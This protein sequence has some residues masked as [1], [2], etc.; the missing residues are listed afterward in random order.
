MKRASG[1]S[2]LYTGA[3]ALLASSATVVDRVLRRPDLHERLGF[4]A[5]LSGGERPVWFHGA[6]VGELSSIEPL[7]LEATRRFPRLAWGVTTTTPAGRRAL[8][9][10][11]PAAA[12]RSFLPIDATP[13][14]DR[15]L[16]RVRP[17]A[18]VFV[19]TEIWPALLARLHA[20]GIPVCFASARV[21]ARSVPR[22]QR[23]RSLFADPLGRVAF[24]AARTEEDGARFRAIGVPEDRVRVM[25]N[26]KLDALGEDVEATRAKA[27][28][29]GPLLGARPRIVWGSLRLGEEDLAFFTMRA[30][31]DRSDILWVVAPRQPA[32]FDR[33][34]D[35]FVRRGL[36]CLRWSR[37]PSDLGNA[38]VL[39]VDTLGELRTFYAAADVAIVGG[40]F[41]NYGGHNLMEPAAFGVPIL[42]GPDTSSW[43]DDAARLLE[44]G[45]GRRVDGAEALAESIRSW[46]DDRDAARRAGERARDAAASGR[47]A[48]ARIVH[49]LVERDF[50][51]L[52]LG[53]AAPARPS[54]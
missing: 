31:S 49:A 30:L 15:F 38:R 34:H 32:E 19:E 27:R 53:D 54:E 44:L 36:S 3:G 20:R 22:Y 52:A 5:P 17:G 42:F 2:M 35:A 18:V 23:L 26:T 10:I 9:R 1:L 11:F 7:V 25:G 28:A 37:N 8:E 33:V 45:G 21:T 46:L 12:F 6:S 50:F 16:D 43:P 40:T 48:S 14:V 39:L 41:G 24:V 13:A 29:L 4:V 47:G 51:R